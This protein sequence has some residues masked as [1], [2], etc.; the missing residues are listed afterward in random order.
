M[1]ATFS[2][3]HAA[4]SPEHAAI[5]RAGATAARDG[6]ARSTNPH[7][8]ESEDWKNWMD[9]FDQQIIWLEQERG[10]YEPFPDAPSVDA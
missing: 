5:V 1:T 4:I 6:I 8:D 9:G 7:S 3:E 2:L 10:I